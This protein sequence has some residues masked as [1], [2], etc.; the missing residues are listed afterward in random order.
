MTSK[1][2]SFCENDL[3]TRKTNGKLLILKFDQMELA[4]N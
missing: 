1:N 4:L 2:C 3:K